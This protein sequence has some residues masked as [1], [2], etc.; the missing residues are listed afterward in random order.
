MFRE[1]FPIVYATDLERSLRFYGDGLDFEPGYRWPAEGQPSFVVLR[2][3]DGAIALTDAASAERLA[4]RTISP[5]APPRFELCLYTDDVD[6]ACERL[7]ALGAR[8]LAAPEDKP[9]GERMAYFEDPDGNP[10]HI[11]ARAGP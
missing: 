9:W 1:P 3:G 11:T 10:I 4:G 8:P 7:L 2:L 5:E 6:R